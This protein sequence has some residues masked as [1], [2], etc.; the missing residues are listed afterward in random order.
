MQLKS[1][2]A[3]LLVF[4]LTLSCK[5]KTTET[6]NLFKFRDYISYTTAGRISVADHINVSLAKT[7]TGWE[8]DKELDKSIFKI[9]PYVEGQLKVVNDHAFT[10]IPDENLSP[11]TEYTVSVKLKDLY[12][13]LPDGFDTYDFSFKTITPNFIIETNN[14]Q[15]YTKELQY[16]NGVLKLAD[17]TTVDK[18]KQLVEASQDGKKLSIVWDE[19]LQPSKYF[20][21][22]IDSITRKI[23]DADILVKWNG[24]PINADNSGENKVTIPGINNFKIV[25]VEVFQLPE[26]FLSINFSDPIKKQQNFDGLVT[27]QNAKNPKFIV[28]GNVLKV[29]PQ[30]KMSGNLKI[31]VFQGIKNTYGYKLKTPYSQTI[32][33]EDIKPQVKLVNSGVFLPNSKELKFNFKAVNLKAVDLRVIKIFE[34]NVLQFLQDNELYSNNNRAIRRVG[35]RIAKHTINLIENPLDNDGKW[36]T[37]SVDLSKYIKADPGAIYRVEIDFKKA[38]SLYDCNATASSNDDDEDYYY[39]DD[40][41]YDDYYN[42]NYN[43]TNTED[44]DLKEEEYWDNLTYSYRNDN[45]NWRE[46]NNPCHESYYNSNRVIAQNLISS[47]LGTIVKKGANNNYLFAVSNILNTNPEAGA[48]IALYNFQQQKIVSSTTNSNGF[49]TISANKHA[50]FATVT[51]GYNTTYVKLNDGNSL[52]L[53]KFDVSGTTLQRGLKGYIYGESGVWRPGDTIHLSFMLND[54]ANKLPKGHPVK[55]EITDPNGKLAF[56]KVKSNGLNNVYTFAVP[57]A[58]EDKTG[59]WNAKIT[60]GGASFYKGLKV[61]T[62]KPNRLKIKIDFEDE[63]LKSN[64]NLKGK[65]A[66][67]WLHGAPAKN[68]KAEVKAK[69]SNSYSGF[70][71]YPD[72]KFRDP[73]KS[74]NTEEITIFEGNL[75]ADG[76]ANITKNLSIGKGAPGMLNAQFLVR[77]FENGGDFSMDAFTMPYAPY[78]SFVGLKSP[79]PKRYG[80]Y[81]TDTNNNFDLVVVDNQGN[82]IQRN[83]LEVKVYKIEWRWWWNSSEDNLSKYTSS[84][85]YK[86]FLE[87]KLNTN[88]KGK[89]S[90]NI[91]VPDEEGGRYYITIKDPISGHSTGQTA[92]FYKNWWKRQPSNDKEAASMLVFSADKENY[93]VGETAKITFP[94]GTSG[95]ALISIENGSEVIEHR[96]V[97]T[98]TG[99]TTVDIPITKQMA[100]NVFVNISLL[101]PHASTAN[102]LPLRLYGVIP[103]MVEDPNTILHPEIKMASVLK[104]KEDYTVFVSEKNN[105]P[106]TY[107]LAVVEEGLLDLTRFKTPNA[108]D[109]FY[110]R[111]AL[112]V[113]TWD[114]FDDVIGAYSGSIDQVFAIGGDG[115]AAAGKNKKANR[116]KPVVTFLGPFKLEAGDRKSHTIKMPNYIGAVRTMVVA[117]HVENEAYGN[118]EKSVQVKQPLMVL[119]SLPRKLSPGEK[120][121]LPVTVFAMEPKV[122]NV[123]LKLK[124]SNGISVVGESSKSLSFEKPDEK[125]EYFELDVSKAKGINTIEVVASGNGE[126]STYKVEIDV[127]NVNPISTKSYNESLTAN[128][129]KTIDFSTF[130]VTGTN[131]ATVEFS[132][133][134]PMDFTRRLEYLIRYPHGCVEQTTSSV[135][136]QLFLTDIFDLPQDQQLKIQDNIKNGIKRLGHFQRPNGGMSYW[137]GENNANDWG[138]SYAGHFMIEAEKKGFVLPLTFKSNWIKYQKEAAQNWRPSY[139]NYNSDLAQAYRLYTLALA[140]SPDLAA[141]NRLREFS[142][143]SNEAKWRLAAAYALAGQTEASNTVA[144]TANIEFQPV[145]RNYY[146]YGSVDRNRAMALE[147]MVITKDKRLKDLAET[148]AKELSSQRWMSTQTTAY[149]LLAMGKMV[150]ANGGKGI[151]INY[152]INGKS[153]TV[154]SNNALAQRD[155]KIKDGANQISIKNNYDNLVYIRILT[156]G[157]LPLGEELTEQR[158]LTANVVFKNLKGDKIDISKLKQ[159]EDFVATVQITNAKN[160]SV[161]DVALTQIFPSGWE[162]VN[163]RFTDFGDNTTSQARFTDIRDDR[164]NFYFDLKQ[165]ET[166]T[167]NVMLNASY[168]GSYYL[169]GIQAEAMY[170]NEFFVRNKGQWIEVE[171]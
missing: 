118:A 147:T 126:T 26:Q 102:D 73:A 122:K 86:P 70:K 1:F 85:F 65:L 50:A 63:I 166:K 109:A 95:R 83:G 157:K 59:N 5:D 149:S 38:Y 140:D 75:D 107:T 45:Y 143:L 60:V 84:S 39:E 150:I 132:T 46:R 112:G 87:S 90:F 57:T 64:S 79:E 4:F 121:T 167:F 44:E 138:T 20:E 131:S 137:I 7:V 89:T 3:I 82:A 71:N 22:K 17:I 2:Y 171:K 32:A 21:F 104:P 154:N 52:S 155:L 49:A 125:M 103:I 74:F 153:E 141:M 31:D 170:D 148:I 30:S 128:E 120:V 37:Y 124:L 110:A 34:D 47:N 55:L 99:E 169:P 127:E 12:N 101:Q 62:V 33:F 15:S 114:I 108:W 145:K 23:D 135:F 13:D 142:E 92:Y 43:Q 54:V 160:Y 35:R 58:T 106:M 152:S 97:K 96:W 88:S 27:I 119:A 113:K 16:L 66:V 40:Y 164:V 117:S 78:N 130:G 36:K 69:F 9:K 93:N 51:K 77:A 165:K 41:Y 67:N 100:P 53:S 129:S 10:F 98:E 76:L 133:L 14:L 161:N 28:D 159:G 25:G 24:K 156:S 11:D 151:K 18:A 116:F 134:P 56:K 72:Y 158:G 81:E 8:A 163:T 139:S 115:N 123:S 94:S 168:L 162:I 48:T 42:D 68:L 105:K 19:K 91:N 6:D 80:S 146:T 136:P 144:K 61:E 111:E 29:Y